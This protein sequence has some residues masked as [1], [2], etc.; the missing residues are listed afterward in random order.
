MTE[1]AIE[2]A[3]QQFWSKRTMI[4]VRFKGVKRG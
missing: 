3:S 1:Q 2:Q 4:V